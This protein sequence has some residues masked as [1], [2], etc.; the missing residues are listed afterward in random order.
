MEIFVWKEIEY[1]ILI[2]KDKSDNWRV[3]DEAKESDVW[4]HVG[5]S[6]SSH[7][8]LETE[9][10]IRNIPRQV[11]T[12]CACIC[13]SKSSKRSEKNC[14]IIYTNIRNVKKTNIVGQV[15]VMGDVKRCTV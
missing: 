8:I 13:K 4:F 6:S 1:R 12:R 14:E 2:G 10:S 11:I 3:I 15:T 5:N 9:E 7:I